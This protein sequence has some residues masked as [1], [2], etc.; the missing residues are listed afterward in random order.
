M[1]TYAL[2]DV[3]TL[4]NDSSLRNRLIPAI[5]AQANYYVAVSPAPSAPTLALAQ[6]CVQNGPGAVVPQFAWQVALNG[7]AQ[8]DA[9]TAP[10]TVVSG[11][12]PD[13]LVA[14]VVGVEW[15]AIAGG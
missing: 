15:A 1:T 6:R 12:V 3:Y 10:G 9:I 7:T 11:N 5:I 14:Y 13:T 2:A 4:G 8:T